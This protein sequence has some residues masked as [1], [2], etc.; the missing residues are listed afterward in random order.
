MPPQKM[1]LDLDFRP[2]TS[3]DVHGSLWSVTPAVTPAGATEIVYND[4]AASWSSRSLRGD[5]PF[6]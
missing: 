5:R 2:Q 1:L 4:H 6:R 3:T